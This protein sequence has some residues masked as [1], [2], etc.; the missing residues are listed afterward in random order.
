MYFG[1]ENL[2][3]K[4][5]Q[6]EILHAVS[7]AFE[8]EKTTAIIGVNGSGKST[9]LRALGRLVRADG[10][11][12]YEA[13]TLSAL[14]SL[15]IA[16]HI[17]LLPQSATCPDDMTVYQLV[18]FGRFPHHKLT[19]QNLS[20]DDHALIERTMR[21]TAVWELRDEKVSALSGGQRQRAFITMCLAQDTDIIL[22]DEPTT[23]LDIV[24]QIDI[25]KLLKMFAK[26]LHKTVIYVL[27][28]LN[29]VARFADNMVVMKDGRI[30]V[31]GS[32]SDVFT[33]EMIAEN[34]GLN[35]AL[36]SDSFSG[37]RMITG[38]SDD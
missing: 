16:S 17:A 4:F 6:K 31:A 24:H 37:S 32:V 13:D 20:A 23:Y 2:S 38:V 26:K 28:D 36:G 18:S 35:V 8:K 3:V 9:L 14:T 21:E 30:S 33:T 1:C 7:V 34:F 5:G 11:I 22:L 15:E 27:H 25:L 29:H 10:T 12:F 19:Q